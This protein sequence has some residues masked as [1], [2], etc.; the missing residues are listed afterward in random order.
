ME[1]GLEGG[2]RFQKARV[3]SVVDG[4]D[5][6]GRVRLEGM[7]CSFS[8]R[9][10]GGALR[11]FPHLL[12]LCIVRGLSCARLCNTMCVASHVDLARSWPNLRHVHVLRFR[13]VLGA[14]QDLVGHAML[15]PAPHP[16]FVE[17]YLGVCA[18]DLFPEPHDCEV[19]VALHRQHLRLGHFVNATSKKRDEGLLQLLRRGRE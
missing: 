7:L 12:P 8:V 5:R 13:E 17:G 6:F 9:G 2:K 14:G 18:A 3:I 4:D 10:L 1:F 15:G 11:L 19:A 16:L